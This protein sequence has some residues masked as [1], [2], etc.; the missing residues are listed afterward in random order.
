LRPAEALKEKGRE[1]SQEGKK[2]ATGAFR[3]IQSVGS[4]FTAAN[5]R[6]FP[7]SFSTTHP[8]LRAVNQ[9]DF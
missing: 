8:L 5:P 2:S 4:F 7:N 1:W 3:P 9:G 6:P